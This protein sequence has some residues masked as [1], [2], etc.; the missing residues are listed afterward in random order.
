MVQKRMLRVKLLET[1]VQ[2]PACL[3]GMGVL[4]V[5]NTGLG[6]VLACFR[7]SHLTDCD[8]YIYSRRVVYPCRNL[9]LQ[10]GYTTS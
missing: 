8:S 2:L 1:L 4:G 10:R 7:L 6:G 9:A 5:R 3:I